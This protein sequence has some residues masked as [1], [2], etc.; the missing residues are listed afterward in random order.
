M[1]D[2]EEI[3]FLRLINKTKGLEKGSW[4]KRSYVETLKEMH[5]SISKCTNVSSDDKVQYE[6]D[7]KVLCKG[8]EEEAAPTP[9]TP[10]P[11]S[12]LIHRR[13]A[14]VEEAQRLKTLQKSVPVP[15]RSPSP[16]NQSTADEDEPDIE[17]VLRVH[18]A[19]QS[20]L[21]DEMLLMTRQLKNIST[22]AHDIIVKD[23]SG[24]S[25]MADQADTNYSKLQKETNKLEKLNE[26]SGKCWVWSLIFLVCLIFI[27]M[28]LFIRLF[29]K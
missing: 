1:R 5:L 8:L 28:V 24:L 11:I 13:R 14:T 9:D 27:V 2:K 3:T 20:K 18:R 26:S 12:E 15:Q 10:S 19:Q 29:P 17:E 21:A 25:S 6:R 22:V 16:F 7:M 23:N 4:R